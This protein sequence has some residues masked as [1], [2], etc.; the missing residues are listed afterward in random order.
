MITNNTITA[1][2]AALGGVISCV[3]ASPTITN[4]ILWDNGA[5]SGPVIY[6]SYSSGIPS[7]LTVRYSDV[8]GGA[9]AAYVEEGSTLDLDST[10]ID[11]DPLFAD[12]DNGDYHL[13]SQYARW[14]PAA[15]DGAGGWI[16][17]TVTSPC[18]DTGDPANDYSNEPPPYGDRINMGA[19]GNAGEASRSVPWWN[20]PGDVNGDCVV[21]VLD[22][23]FVRNTFLHNTASG[24]NW[25]ADVDS[26][27]QIDV[28]D[29]LIVREAMKDEC[30]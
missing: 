2:T 22:M 29:M 23:L 26:D 14:D 30:E 28:L 25:K 20:I 19:Y 9:G 4:S 6:L 11:A 17:D 1:N 13:K 15:N 21:N 24:D 7:T 8:E 12:P 10:N 27:G 5:P 16:T 18:I 3:Y